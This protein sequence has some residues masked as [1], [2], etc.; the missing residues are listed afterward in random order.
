M[1]NAAGLKSGI[2]RTVYSNGINEATYLKD[3]KHGLSF[4]WVNHSTMAFKATIFEHGKDK[5]W[6]QWKSDWSEYNS[7]GDKELILKNGGL[8]LLKP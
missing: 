3:K 2:V 4:W 8:S 1:R 6:I 7:R 5:A